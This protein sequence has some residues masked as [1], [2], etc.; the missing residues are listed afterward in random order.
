[1][2]VCQHQDLQVDFCRLKLIQDAAHTDKFED[3]LAGKQYLT[4][5]LHGEPCGKTFFTSNLIT[6]YLSR[7]KI[8]LGRTYRIDIVYLK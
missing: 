6:R 1:M 7:M 8:K 5:I 3:Q 4:S 2:Q